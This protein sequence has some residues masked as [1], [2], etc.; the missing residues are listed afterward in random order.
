MTAKVQILA[1]VRHAMARRSPA[2]LGEIQ[3]VQSGKTSVAVGVVI[4]PVNKIAKT[5]A[6][7]MHDFGSDFLELAKL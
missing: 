3:V 4:Q 2:G 6:E 7:V 1:V 5:L